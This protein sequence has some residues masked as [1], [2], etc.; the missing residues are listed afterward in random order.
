MT[1]CG[2][3][4]ST[5]LFGG[6]REGEHRFCNDRCLAGGRLLSASDRVS[7]SDV[8]RR[9]TEI[10]QGLCPRCS[11]SGPVDVHVSHRIWSALFLTSWNS[12]PTVSCRGCGRKAQAGGLLYSA[13]LGWWGFPWGLI[14]TPVQIVRNVTALLRASESMRPSADLERIV[15]LELAAQAMHRGHPENAAAEAM[16]R[17]DAGGGYL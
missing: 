5:I 11:G 7:A 4:N 16:S 14:M 10:H 13:T 9:V 2:Y 1:R 6:E 12:T 17:E 15:R 8:E 3:C